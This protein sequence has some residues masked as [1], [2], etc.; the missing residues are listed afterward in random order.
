VIE[1]AAAEGI[2]YFNSAKTY[3]GSESYYG[4]FWLKNSALKLTFFK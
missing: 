3:A 1:E 4:K 2:T